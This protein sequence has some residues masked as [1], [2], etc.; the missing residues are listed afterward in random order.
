MGSKLKSIS[1]IGFGMVA[2]AAISLQLS[3]LAQ[4]DSAR[5]LPLEKLGEFSEIFGLIKSDYV[6]PVDDEKLLTD[7]ISGMVSSLDPHSSYLDKDALKELRESTEGKFVGLGIE[8]GTEDGYVKVISPIEDSPAFRAGIQAGDLITRIDSVPVKG[9]SIDDAVKRL[10]G[11]PNTKIT[12]TIARKTEDKPVVV[13]LVRE[14]IK[15]HSVKAKLI[16]PGYAWIR[17]SQFQEPTVEEMVKRIQA[18][19]AQD[20]QLKGL[21][22]DLRNDPGGVLPGAIGVSA[23]FLPKDVPIVST[24]GQVA[25]AKQVYYAKPEFYR[26]EELQDPLLKLPAAAKKIPMVVLIN[27]GSAS[28]S[29]IVAGAL[30]DYQRAT[31]MGT[32]SF[33]KGSVQTVHQITENTGVKITTARYYTPN[34]RAIQAKGITPDLQVEETESGDSF[35]SL[36]TRE[37]DLEK[38]LK[39]DKDAEKEAERAQ[40]RVDE[41]EEE[42]RLAGLAKKYK[43]FEYGSKADFQLRQALNYLKGLPLQVAQVAKAKTNA[44]SK[45]NQKATKEAKGAKKP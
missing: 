28:A 30:Q 3:A 24:N 7:A 33:G 2:G 36:R 44:T 37:V 31:I 34:G 43:P 20:P 40:D 17:I 26:T 13:T 38:H 39:N 14:L 29:E 42:Q 15:Q 16:E 4:K 5:S 11:A 19:Y 23:A 32:R 1:L 6:E 25:D 10:R 18:L 9:L 27:G 41:L 22:L 35:N 8:V 12:L 21:V 45:S